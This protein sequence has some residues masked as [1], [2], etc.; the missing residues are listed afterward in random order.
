MAVN[1]F[2]LNR[3]TLRLVGNLF[4][5][6]QLPIFALQGQ[7]SDVTTISQKNLHLSSCNNSK[8]VSNQIFVITTKIIY[9]GYINYSLNFK[10]NL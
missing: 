5:R 9:C 2:N 6:C 3:G 10:D 4:S 1:R 8:I 7:F